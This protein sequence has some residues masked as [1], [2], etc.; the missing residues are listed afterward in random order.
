[1]S[2]NLEEQFWGNVRDAGKKG[3]KNGNGNGNNIKLFLAFIFCVFTF[4]WVGFKL[5]FM[6]PLDETEARPEPGKEVQQQGQVD[7]DGKRIILV[8]GVDQRKNE[9]A[10]ADT[11]MLAFLDEK[12][13]DISFISVPRDTYVFVPG[14]RDNTKINHAYAYGG[15]TMLINT[16]E[17]FLKIKIDHYME[18]NFQGFAQTVDALGGIT[19]DVEKKMYYPAEHIDLKAG[20]QKLNGEQA[21]A[22]VRYR[23]DGM[24]DIGRIERQQKFLHVM[25]DHILRVSTVW[26]IPKLAGVVKN[27]IDTDLQLKDLLALANTYK[28]I[29]ISSI[30]TRMLPGKAEYINGVSYWVVYRDEVAA[31]IAELL[32]KNLETA[33]T[34]ETS[35]EP[36]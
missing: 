30:Q 26:K 20:T 25:A 9:P 18:T 27:N 28:S 16:L 4:L 12:T 35:K 15:K 3:K 34:P 21:L 6:F 14:R 10:R 19:I 33:G 36:N 32:N 5:S 2:N 23:S 29:D 8:I 31:I 7:D 24:G 17:H 1:M 22:Y 13:K 11:I